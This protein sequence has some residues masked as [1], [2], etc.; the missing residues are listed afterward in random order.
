MR[1]GAP[2]A[3]VASLPASFVAATQAGRQQRLESGKGQSD[4]R[5][6]QKCAA[7]CLAGVPA[8]QPSPLREWSCLMAL[9]VPDD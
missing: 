9:L 5:T 8:L 4:T 2:V 6:A 3:V 1:S 7:G